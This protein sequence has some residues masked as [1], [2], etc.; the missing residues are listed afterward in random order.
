MNRLVLSTAT[1]AVTMML[2]C[3]SPSDTSTEQST[4][5]TESALNG[6]VCD[7]DVDVNSD[8]DGAGPKAYTLTSFTGTTITG[9]NGF[10][11]TVTASFS[12]DTRFRLANLN[13]FI[14]T[15]PI[16]PA[17]ITYNAAVNA[18]SADISGSIEDLVSF[19][20]HA[21]LNVKPGTT[22]IRSFRPV[23]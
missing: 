19:Q 7:V 23:P 21:R 16:R 22:V 4:D 12:P 10:G 13:R 8:C 2:G 11:Q 1:I 17:L 14:P 3:S 5:S 6:V 18:Q 15:D 20:V 9:V